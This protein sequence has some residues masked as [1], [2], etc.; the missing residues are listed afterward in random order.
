MSDTIR[1]MAPGE[2]EMNRVL[3]AAGKVQRTREAHVNAVAERND[4]V[5][6]A[7]QAGVKTREVATAAKISQPRV[8]QIA[9]AD[10]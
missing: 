8:V 9:G 2:I 4:A 7:V 1:T 10:K 3:R 5:T 6:A